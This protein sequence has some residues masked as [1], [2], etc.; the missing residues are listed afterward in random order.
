MV[1]FMLLS[2]ATNGKG[3]YCNIAYRDL[4]RTLRIRHCVLS[5]MSVCLSIYPTVGL[6]V[7]SSVCSSVEKNK[8]G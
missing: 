4:Y 6:S 1:C 5:M 7:C 8:I 3:R 2:I